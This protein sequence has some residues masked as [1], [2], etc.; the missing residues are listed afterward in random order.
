VL[1]LISL[2]FIR[3]TTSSSNSKRLDEV[4][5][6]IPRKFKVVSR[7]TAAKMG[8]QEGTTLLCQSWSW[9]SERMIL[10][11]SQRKCKGAKEEEEV[12]EEEEEEEEG[13][14][15]RMIRGRHSLPENCQSWCRV[16][17]KP[18]TKTVRSCNVGCQEMVTV[19][20]QASCNIQSRLN[21]QN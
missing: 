14:A 20:K 10:V 15:P 13:T 16:H 6:R 5:Q 4:T 9:G 2:H 12:V 8:G 1:V 18:A 17:M 19:E 7:G 21:D 3:T 11:R